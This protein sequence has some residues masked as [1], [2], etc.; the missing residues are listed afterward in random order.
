M[1]GPPEGGH[2]IVADKQV[3]L[4]ADT[5]SLRMGA[6]YAAADGRTLRRCGWADT[7]SLRMG[8]HYVAADGRTLR[9]CG[10]YVVSGFSRT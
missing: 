9:R 10:R 5:T 7:T 3:R 4:K 6:H 1:T 8:G 2:Y